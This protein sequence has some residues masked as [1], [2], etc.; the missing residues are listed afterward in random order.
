MALQ[1]EWF[2]GAIGQDGGLASYRLVVADS[3]EAILRS[4]ETVTRLYEE[5]GSGKK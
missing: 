3:S 5:L 4:M 1:W 2:Q